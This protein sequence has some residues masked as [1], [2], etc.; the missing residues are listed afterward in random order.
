MKH[1]HGDS[2]YMNMIAKLSIITNHA[3]LEYMYAYGLSAIYVSQVSS[4]MS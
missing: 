3:R 4:S 2:E 1:D